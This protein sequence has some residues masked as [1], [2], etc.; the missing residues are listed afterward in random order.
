M[1]TTQQH[2]TKE[3]AK[4]LILPRLS[5]IDFTTEITIDHVD[6]DPDYWYEN[7]EVEKV[8]GDFKVTIYLK[9][10][11][12]VVGDTYSIDPTD[13]PDVE[14]TYFE[15]EDACLQ[16]LNGEYATFYNEEKEQEE[17]LIEVSEMLEAL[18]NP[19]EPKPESTYHVDLRFTVLTN[20]DNKAKVEVNRFLKLISEIE[21]E[22]KAIE[23]T[24][25]SIHRRVSQ[26]EFEKIA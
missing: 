5:E 3:E 9:A 24:L 17:E 16:L 20:S 2:L 19:F 14:L 10:H 1:A 21:G 23:P 22:H 7:K 4:T 11:Y 18:V 13:E 8:I 15:F 26:N 6:Y 12:D 25:G